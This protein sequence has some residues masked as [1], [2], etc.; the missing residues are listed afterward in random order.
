MSRDCSPSISD[1]ATPPDEAAQ[2]GVRPGPSTGRRRGPLRDLAWG[3]LGLV[4][5]AGFGGLAMGCEED[6]SVD[7]DA[8]PCPQVTSPAPG[9]CLE[10]RIETVEVDNAC[11][12]ITCVPD[13]CPAYQRPECAE[14]EHVEVTTSAAGCNV[15]RC[16]PD[17]CPQVAAPPADFCPEG[18]RIEQYVNNADCTDFRCVPAECPVYQRPIC[19]EGEHVETFTDASGCTVP[20]C[21]PFECPQVAAPPADFCPAGERVDQY[22]NEAGCTDFRCVP[23][24]CPVYQI[25]QCSSG[26]HVETVLNEQACYEP[27]CVADLDPC[28]TIAAP[29]ATFCP[30]GQVLLDEIQCQWVCHGGDRCPSIGV[31]AE[32]QGTTVLMSDPE[33]HCL[34]G[35]DCQP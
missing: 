32:C 24:E 5:V 23:A 30:G 6:S 16:V 35:I 3:L 10:G 27:V 22:V 8:G 29:D 18:E 2:V 15:P 25:P 12:T 7:P 4:M 19:S 20:R 33:T 1:T 11:P 28:S 21:A 26:E 34:T 17:V 14:G 9:F 31:F 13:E